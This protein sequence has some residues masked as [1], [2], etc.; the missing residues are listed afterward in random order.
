[1]DVTQNKDGSITFTSKA[2][3]SLT[4]SVRDIDNAAYLVK[5]WKQKEFY[6]NHTLKMLKRVSKDN[7]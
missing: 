7:T 3:E 5:E 6:K 1:M 4:V 2:N